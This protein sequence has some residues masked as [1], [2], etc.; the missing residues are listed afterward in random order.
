MVYHTASV[1]WY[2]NFKN[3]HSVNS[4][5]LHYYSLETDSP[6]NIR[7]HQLRPEHQ[8][9]WLT[10][11]WPSSVPPSKCGAIVSNS[12]PETSFH[13]L[14]KSIFVSKPPIRRYSIRAIDNVV[15]WDINKYVKCKLQEGYRNTAAPASAPAPQPTH[16]LPRPR[17]CC[18]KIARPDI[19][20][21]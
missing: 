17:R 8:R 18:S 20:T 9:P 4:V 11:L 2:V 14:A 15:K 6:S 12:V 1:G 21:C 16:L 10:F 3:M 19:F 13:V 5:K 7:R